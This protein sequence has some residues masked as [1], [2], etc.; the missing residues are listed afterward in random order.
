MKFSNILRTNKCAS[1][2]A[3]NISEDLI[4]KEQEHK[5]KTKK[6]NIDMLKRTG[7]VAASGTALYKTPS[8][9]HKIIKNKIESD[10]NN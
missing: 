9:I 4:N 3:E 1:F 5:D 2:L 10:I 6:E 7:I 8:I